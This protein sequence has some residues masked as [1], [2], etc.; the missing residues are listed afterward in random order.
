MNTRKTEFVRAVL[1]AMMISMLFSF[2]A[3]NIKLLHGHATNTVETCASAEFWSMFFQRVTS[4]RG[5][6]LLFAGLWIVFYFGY[7]IDDYILS[8]EADKPVR[9][10]QVPRPAHLMWKYIGKCTVPN[11]H[12]FRG[13]G[14]A[15]IGHY[16]TGRLQSVDNQNHLPMGLLVGAWFC[17]LAQVVSVSF[18][19]LSAAFG[20]AGLIAISIVILADRSSF[21]LWFFE[22]VFLWICMYDCIWQQ[23][24]FLK[25]AWIYFI[26]FY[27]E[28]V[29]SICLLIRIRKDKRA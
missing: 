13:K 28:K 10:T 16:N 23:D 25:N 14:V 2:I 5:A 15:F 9:T 4:V 8:F 11:R 1:C 22:N 3:S 18:M 17:F 20:M 6:H 27:I 29:I 26:V 12:V 21:L 7:L 24:C 19:N